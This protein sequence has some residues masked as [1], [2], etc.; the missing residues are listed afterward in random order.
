[1]LAFVADADGNVIAKAENVSQPS[2]FAKWLDE[3]AA[4]YERTHPTTRIPF[5][6]AQVVGEGEGDARKASCDALETALADGRAVLLYVGRS[7]R[8]DDAK[9][10]RSVASA[11]RKFEK[12]TLGSKQAA[13]VASRAVLLRL[14][15][16]DPDHALVA[17]G[18]GVEKV[19][20]LL[21]WEP[22]AEKPQDLGGRISGAALAAKLKK[23]PVPDSDDND[24]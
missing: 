14:D 24:E 18:L 20:T 2:A 17:G 5:V 12:K 6:R 19:P 16:G 22:G 15:L 1:V 8:P 9:A 3:Q 10:A 21:L 7:E 13:E 4:E 23:L 11:S